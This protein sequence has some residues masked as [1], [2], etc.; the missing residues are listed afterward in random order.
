MTRLQWH[1]H[2]RPLRT[3][4]LEL[5][6]RHRRR[7][8]GHRIITPVPV[9]PFLLLPAL[10]PTSS[11]HLLTSCHLFTAT[12]TTPTEHQRIAISGILAI[13]TAIID[14]I[15]FK[16][17]NETRWWNY[18]TKE[19]CS[20]NISSLHNPPTLGKFGPRHSKSQLVKHT[21][22]YEEHMS[23]LFK[24]AFNPLKEEQP[25]LRWVGWSL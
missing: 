25:S 16:I 13:R 9:R 18:Q 22:N 3:T 14:E 1:L 8:M 12:S 7:T 19:V 24:T 17:N 4:L 20:C 2:Q 5:I 11:S 6:K 10:F 21:R 23:L 15:F